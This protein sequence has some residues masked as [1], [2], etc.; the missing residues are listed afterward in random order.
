MQCVASERLKPK[1]VLNTVCAVTG[2][3][4]EAVLAPDATT[5]ALAAEL[6]EAEVTP[7]RADE[8]LNGRVVADLSIGLS[9]TGTVVD[10]VC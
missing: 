4:D 7:Y 3:P 8:T 10:D 5:G 1:G 6:D 2:T 9:A